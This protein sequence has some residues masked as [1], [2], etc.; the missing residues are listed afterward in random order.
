MKKTILFGSLLSLGTLVHSQT[1]IT[2]ENP[3]APEGFSQTS[4][5]TTEYSAQG[6]IFSGPS[7]GK[8]GA[9]LQDISFPTK[10]YYGA[11]NTFLAFN[12]YSSG[13]Y[14][15]GPETL[16]FDAPHGNVSIEVSG[17]DASKQV[18]MNAYDSL[19][20]L[21]DSTT[22]TAD[23]SW[24][25]LSVSGPD[26]SKVVISF[27]GQVTTFNDLSFDAAVPTPEPG[28]L[29]LAGLGLAGMAALRR[30]K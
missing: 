5:L 8:G 2:L 12:S 28:T 19:D 24:S 26:I 30:K 15:I 11:G 9:I 27:S 4:A 6:V 23:A 20:S 1:V 25:L 13:S 22:I 10:S 18:T 21:L 3:S 16:T 29:A 14:S 7:A 17:Q